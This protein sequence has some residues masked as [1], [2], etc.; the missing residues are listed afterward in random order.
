MADDFC[1]LTTIGRRSG[2]PHEIEIWYAPAPDGRTLYLLAGGRDGADWV[3]NLL[4]EPACTVRI[5]A[6]DAPVR[7]ARGRVVEDPDEMRLARTL[8]FEK[9]QPRYGDDLSTW[10]ESALPLALD[11]DP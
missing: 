11:L 3:R 4:A 9:F 1:Y 6:R 2:R 8:V 10:R 5:D 7:G